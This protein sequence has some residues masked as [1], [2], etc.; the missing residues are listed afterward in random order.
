MTF[1]PSWI[2]RP[3]RPNRPHPV[4]PGPQWITLGVP[5]AEGPVIY[6]VVVLRPTVID[7]EGRDKLLIRE[8]H[9][10]AGTWSW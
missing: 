7:R 1:V 3:C 6:Q 2:S 9:R 5:V 8:A 10:I 4:Q